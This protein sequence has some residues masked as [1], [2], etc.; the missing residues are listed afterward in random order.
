MMPRAPTSKGAGRRPIRLHKQLLLPL[1]D[2]C[3]R[4]LSLANHLALVGCGP[5]A[6]S[7]HAVNNL[8]RV[9]YLSFFL[10]EAGYG[11]VNAE[12]YVSAERVLDQ[13]VVRAEQTELWCLDI[14]EVPVM[15][16]VLRIHDRQISD[17]PTRAFL[18]AKARLESVLRKEHT[19]SPIAKRLR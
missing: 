13:V 8:I 15:Q 11:D 7:R 17:A 19:V 2:E 10:W 18:E 16:K 4:E 3:V 14:E 1:P 6:G 12:F 9:T 5:S